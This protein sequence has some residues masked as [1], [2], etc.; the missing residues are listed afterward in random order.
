MAKT[1][2]RIIRIT[3]DASRAGRGSKEVVNSMKRIEKQTKK[4]NKSIVQMGSSIN[5]LRGLMQAFIV[6]TGVAA[7]A[8]LADSYTNLNSRIKLVTDSTEEHTKVLN[9]LDAIAS[10]TYSSLEA[11]AQLYNRISTSMEH[12]NITADQT[13]AITEG[14]AHTFRISGATAQE[15]ASGLIQFSQG[16]A[17][18]RFQGDELRNILEGN[19]AMQR[20]FADAMG[21]TTAELKK[22]GAEGKITAAKVLPELI[23]QMDKLREQSAK[24]APTIGGAFQVLTNKA[25]LF[26]GKLN[27]MTNVSATF[28]SMLKLVAHNLEVISVI[29]GSLAGGAALGALAKGIALVTT[30]MIAMSVASKVAW[31]SMS[32]GI[33]GSLYLIWELYEGFDALGFG[34]TMAALKVE[35]AFALMSFGLAALDNS[36]KGLFGEETQDRIVKNVKDKMLALKILNAQIL[37]VEIDHM[38]AANKYRNRGDSPL[39]NTNDLS[40][41]KELEAFTKALNG[42]GGKKKPKKEKADP[43]AQRLK[44]LKDELEMIG[45]VTRASK[46]Q[47]EINNMTRVNQLKAT[48]EELIA[49]T[50]LIEK[51]QAEVDLANRASELKKELATSTDAL[52]ASYNSATEKTADYNKMLV[53]GLITEKEYVTATSL[54][55]E[56]YREEMAKMQPKAIELTGFMKTLH[57][58]MD[59]YSQTTAEGLVDMTELL[60]QAGAGWE[61]FGDIVK[62]V[63]KSIARDIAVMGTKSFITDLMAQGLQSQM[64]GAPSGGGGGSAASVAPVLLGGLSSASSPSAPPAPSFRPSINASPRINVVN[65]MDPSV[66]GEYLNTKDGEDTMVNVLSTSDSYKAI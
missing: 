53:A 39:I 44:A 3:V 51:K 5:A 25:T 47:G 64:T 31:A 65:V 17:A 34:V 63:V 60:F 12:Y 43:M 9:G 52:A 42:A 30:R 14:V 55:W 20:V 11:N 46:I 15:A 7:I 66:V 16:L 50:A 24:V 57:D 61:D 62:N 10:V 59:S 40:F 22:L 1:T 49:T 48:K 18:G 35:K 2:E 23:K 38:Q 33:S 19:I 41:M 54:A 6:G 45:R 58:S 37:Q 8:K 13:L 32:L 29:V 27:E 4:T 26:I 36:V 21:T 56:T 28:G